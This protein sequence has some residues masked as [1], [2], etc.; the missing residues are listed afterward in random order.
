MI[1]RENLKQDIKNGEYNEVFEKLYCI[2]DP[3]DMNFYVNRYINLIESFEKTFGYPEEVS[4]FSAPGRTEIGGNHTD[5]QRG[6][7]VAGSV[8]LDV[9]AVSALN[10]S[11]EI[12]V[13]SEGYPVDIININE[14]EPNNEEY[15]SSKS[16]I[17]GVV[18]KIKKLGY[19]IKGFDCYTVSNVLKGSG[20]SSSAAFEMLI[21]NIINGM[22]CN[23]EINAVEIAKIGQ[24]AE[25][26]YF[27]KPCGLMDQMASSVGG[28]VFI[29]FNDL[30][31]PIIKKINFDFSSSDYALC[32][33]D[34]GAD[35][36][37]LT[38]EYAAIPS[39][40]K[41]I[42]N[43]FEK[44][45]LRDVDKKDFIAAIPDLRKIAGD[46]AV[47]RA[48]HFFDEN[49]RAQKEAQALDISNFKDFLSL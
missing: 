48:L 32:I 41:K 39:E 38:D 25:N 3:Y 17:K 47:L 28:I 36:A 4:L 21:G 8:N 24:F 26:V 14:L 15:N 22:F 27:G 42:A 1:K 46:R 18:A 13:K 40:M 37:N 30:E 16:L 29:D 20:L 33:I 2:K 11:D 34:S 10:N 43:Y 7:V 45:V 23:N 6:C 12:R 49:L 44:D 35:H 5:H 31:N 19:E 9:I